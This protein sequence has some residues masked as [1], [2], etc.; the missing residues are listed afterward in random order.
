MKQEYLIY[1]RHLFF[2]KKKSKAEYA[3]KGYTKKKNIRDR[4]D[5]KPNMTPKLR[6]FFKLLLFESFIQV[7]TTYK[8][9]NVYIFKCTD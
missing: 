2:F 9:R 3:G 5:T 6:G 1:K 4:Y 8:R 7:D